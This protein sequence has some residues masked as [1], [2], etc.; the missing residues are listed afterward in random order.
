MSNIG[1]YNNSAT[2]LE[3]LSKAASVK[4]IKLDHIEDCQFDL[5][6]KKYCPETQP[7]PDVNNER[8]E[9]KH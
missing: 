9:T 2:G 7:A 4:F 3:Q 6:I 5:L 1:A 8:A